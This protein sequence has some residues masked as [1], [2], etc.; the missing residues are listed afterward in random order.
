MSN[1]WTNKSRNMQIRS[2][3]IINS[4][5]FEK[6]HSWALALR[7][8]PSALVFRQS[9]SQ[10]GTNAFRYWTVS[11]YQTGS[12][13]SIIVYS[14][15]GLKGCETV[16][17]LQN[18]VRDTPCTSILLVLKGINTEHPKCWWLKGY[19]LHVCSAGVERNTPR[20]STLL[21]VKGIHPGRS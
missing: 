7:P 19:T 6:I 5:I 13:N 17:H 8:M 3:S 14:G 2:I 20:K 16:R 9:V 11:P 10:S 15:I 1:K 12:D 21:V 18:V 4:R